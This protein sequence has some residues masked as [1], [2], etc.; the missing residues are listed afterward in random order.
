[1]VRRKEDGR[2]VTGRGRYVDDLRPAE[3]LHLAIVRG[4]HAHARIVAIDAGP[5]RSIEGVAGVF[6]LDDLPELRGVLPPPAVAAVELQDYRQS[7]LADGLVRFAGEP[8]VAVVA[9]TPYVARDAA[10]AVAVEYEPLP[11]AIDPA[12]ATA[13]D[14]APV[15][16]PWS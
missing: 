12:H 9:A 15:H 11:A 10:A 8:V 7:A 3:A 5:A 6:T 4:V 1:S 13:A 16:G 2:F 14:A